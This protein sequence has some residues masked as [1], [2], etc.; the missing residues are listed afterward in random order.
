[1]K[2]LA[3]VAFVPTVLAAILGI[4]SVTA[5]EPIPVQITAG[6]LEMGNI[7]GILS[8]AG[9]HGFT[10][11]GGVTVVG[12]VFGP[13][14][15]CTPCLPGE[16]VSLSSTW[17]G[18]DLAGTA[19]FQ[20]VTY[21][22]VGSLASGHAFG[23]VTFSGPAPLAPPLE[24]LSSTVIAPFDFAGQFSFPA[25]GGGAGE[26][27]ALFGSGTATIGLFRSSLDIPWSYANASF[28]FDQVDPVPEPGTLL[29]VG[30]ALAG[31][32]ARR[33]RAAG[34]G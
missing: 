9:D 28:T 6:S 19:T 4:P 5:A 12:G 3:R 16:P 11:T 14:N 29:L 20:G 8:L 34:R 10:F 2:A 23:T 24:G 17:G 26:V 27:A 1:M 30:T 18:N 15:A 22:Q 31:L 32:A 21:T 25:M 33:R 7:G 13:R